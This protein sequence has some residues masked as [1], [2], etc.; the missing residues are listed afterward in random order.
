MNIFAALHLSSAMLMLGI[1]YLYLRFPP[2]EINSVYGYRTS[3]SMR[4]IDAWKLANSFSARMMFILACA[5]VPV[6]GILYVAV[7]EET[8]LLAYCVILCLGLI[9]LIPLTEKHLKKNGF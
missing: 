7:D 4:S 8:S 2:K 5:L 6:Q 9:A 1:S 3:R